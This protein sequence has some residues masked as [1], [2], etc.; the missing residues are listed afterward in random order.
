MSHQNRASTM[1]LCRDAICFL[2]FLQLLQQILCFSNPTVFL[3]KHI[4]AEVDMTP[5]C[6]NDT[7]NFI[8]NVLC[9]IQKEENGDE[10]KL[11]YLEGQK[12]EPECD[13]RISLMVQNHSVFLRLMDLTPADSGMYNCSCIKDE[14]ILRRHLNVTV[15][16]AQENGNGSNSVKTPHHKLLWL[17]ALFGTT[18]I[19]A[20][21]ILVIFVKKK[22]HS[23]QQL[24]TQTDVTE[25]QIEPYGMFIETRSGLYSTVKLI[26]FE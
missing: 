21:L 23:R 19:I 9:H 14:S 13:S 12:N 11:N 25:E 17:I 10:C 15:K 8:T 20:P 22:L 3:E 26:M 1:E 6:T 24:E 4:G 16:E 18:I 5:L 2:F 7:D